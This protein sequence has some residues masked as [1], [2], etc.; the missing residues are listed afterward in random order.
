MNCRSC[1]EPIASGFIDEQFVHVNTKTLHIHECTPVEV[2]RPAFECACGEIV[3][4]DVGGLRREWP[5]L[6]T[7]IHRGPKPAPMPKPQG[8]GGERA[9]K[10]RAFKGIEI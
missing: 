5:G 10:A 6:A 1:G 7:H 3:I 2:A 9:G 8:H 4:E